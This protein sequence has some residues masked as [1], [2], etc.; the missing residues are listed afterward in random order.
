MHIEIAID[1]NDP[2]LMIPFYMNLLGYR[3]N[4]V[5]NERYGKDQIYYSCIDPS[6]KGPQIIFQVVP[7]KTSTKS[8]I[9]LDFHVPNV[10]K[11][12]NEAV[13][14]GA[15]QIDSEPIYE[16]GTHWIRLADPEGNIFCIVH[17]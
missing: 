2:Q 15:T 14:L 4:D 16:A 10:E 5:D 7:E 17:Q 9:H 11:S 13:Q 12:T 6:G 8:R 1:I 3:P